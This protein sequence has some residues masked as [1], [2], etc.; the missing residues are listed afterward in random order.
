MSDADVEIRLSADSSDAEKGISSLRKEYQDLIQALQKPIRQID[1]LQKSQAS[2]KEASS[3]YFAARK[4][5]ADLRRAIESAGQP[6]ADLDRAYAKAQRT[7]ASTTR[8][9][10]RQKRAVRE[11]RAELRAAGID[12]TK[13]ASEQQRLQGSLG[14][15]I[16]QGRG[17]A[18]ITAA[19]D[20]F[21]I[22]QLR[23]LRAQLVQLDA[24]YKRL[25]Q[26]GVLSARERMVAEVQYQA[27][28][29]Q[30]KR[31]IGDLAD[32][33]GALGPGF[34]DMAGRLAA[35]VGVA[36]TVQQAAGAF[37]T[38]A[39]AVVTM[40]DRMRGAVS[41]EEEFERSLERL[42]ETSDRV[43][44]PLAQTSDLFIGM[45]RPL[46]EMGFSA[47]TTAD[48]VAALSAGLVTSNVKGQKAAEVIAQLNKGLQTGVIR[49]DAFKAMLDN[50]PTLIQALTDGLRV[51]RAE[52]I[53]MAE[54]GEITT[55]KFVTALSRQSDALLEQADTMR[56]TVGDAM[57]TLGDKVNKVVGSIDKLTGLSAAAVKELDKVS[58]ALD[59]AAEGDAG[60]AFDWLAE[61]A[62]GNGSIVADALSTMWQG[63]QKFEEEATESIEN[64]VSAE[65]QAASRRRE[66][67]EQELSA[68]RSYAE[69]FNGITDELVKKFENALA[70]QT[71]AQSK[72]NSA[73]TKAQNEQL[74]T[75]KRYKDALLKL[76][77]GAA[78]PA[79]YGAAQGLQAAARQALQS[80]NVES[81]KRNA[82]AALEMLMK[83][84][85][86][87]ENTYGFEGM[88][89]QLQ[90][91]EQEA[92]QI[93]LTK[94]KADL[95]A[96]RNKTREW[97]AELKELKNFTITPNIS[98]EDLA[99]ATD[100]LRNWAKMIGHDIT[101]SP[102]LL[103][104]DDQSTGPTSALGAGL[105]A[106]I[107]Q[108]T[109]P[110][111]AGTPAKPATPVPV[112]VQP[113]GIRQ[114]GNSFT[115]LPAVAVDVKP[116][117]IR[118]DGDNSFTNLPAVPVD[119]IPRG[120]RQDGENSFTNL[121]PVEMETKLD[122]QSVAA[123]KDAVSKLAAGLQQQL[124]IQVSIG[125][126]SAPEPSV[127]GFARGGYTGHGARTA[128][129]GIVHRGEV[130]WSQ[131][132]IARAGGVA[133]VE[134]MRRGLRGYSDGGPVMSRLLP[135]LPE[136]SADLQP[137]PVQQDLPYLG[138][139]ALDLG[140]TEYTVYTTADQANEL[141][142]AA[143]KFGRTSR[144]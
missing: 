108:I 11:Q 9:F 26:S 103:P 45:V 97:K 134:G 60:G 29:N 113:V 24:D 39:D 57:G 114:E 120:I 92:D 22:N 20:R 118:N 88:I 123:T 61:K 79:S 44:I 10:E 49:G 38:I 36:Y 143:M 132:D 34:Q 6:V 43:R 30:T 2:A 100:K 82:Q 131:Q 101:V 125:G 135:N 126:L 56:S 17:D 87:G 35:I 76:N 18:A 99:K 69:E 94:A 42:E 3:A 14:T 68:R 85:E 116:V 13:L 73:L 130:V 55:E 112:D 62:K 72:A 4:N 75:Q 105:N 27:Q 70:D 31:A 102:R 117:G 107:N 122:E 138:K 106:P 28:V 137:A 136:Y 46:K 98:D 19:A 86:A 78:G 64:V 121:P 71:A 1:A 83:L 84:A 59:M 54:A 7:L 90:A 5:V 139:M 81:A 21:G 50:A 141:K 115:N 80:G 133:V 52:L 77:A 93:K 95:D 65:E 8:E 140:G 37:F 66:L 15:A 53:R 32:S 47:A 91:I 67:E 110:L 119:I 111:T 58:N 25:T 33:Q 142:L 109:K 144:R 127:P 12:V 48:T 40:E 41:S 96:A 129:A 51:S 16:G 124:S 128:P 23:N 74:A 104:D 63:Y 89:K